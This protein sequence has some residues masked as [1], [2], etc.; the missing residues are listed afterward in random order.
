MPSDG[1]APRR[2]STASSGRDRSTAAKPSL[3]SR[4]WPRVSARLALQQ[5][6][7]G[8]ATMSAAETTNDAALIQYAACGPAA[9]VSTPPRIGPIAQ[10]TFSIVWRSAFA[11]G[12]S[13]VGHEV[14]DA[15][16]DGRPEEPAREARDRGERD[17]LPRPRRERQRGEH[18][19][20]QDVRADHEL[21]PLE[22][23]EQRPER[24]PDE[25]RR[26]E[27]DDEDGADPEAR[28]RPV[29]DVDRERD[30]GEERAD[31]RPEGRRG[32]AGGSPRLRRGSELTADSCQG[33]LRG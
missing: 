12:S 18:R 15:G 31:A 16:V 7:A 17:D 20:A 24:E 19:G 11:S 2:T 23:V 28:V 6:R 27:L 30:R 26:Q 10:L 9:A 8:C 3:R 1:D 25:D 29:L 4:Q 33:V 22:P 5:L 21:A 32:R 13:S 14:R